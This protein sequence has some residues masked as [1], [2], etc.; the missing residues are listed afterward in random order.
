METRKIENEIKTEIRKRIQRSLNYIEGH[1][2]LSPEQLQVIEAE[3]LGVFLAGYNTASE[4][5]NIK[6]TK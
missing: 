3:L 5:L 1:I 2:H 6:K 4:I